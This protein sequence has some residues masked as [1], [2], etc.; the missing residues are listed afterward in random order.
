MTYREMPWRHAD[1]VVSIGATTVSLEIECERCP[2]SKWPGY[3]NIAPLTLNAARKRVHRH[4]AATGHI[5][6]VFQSV[7]R[8]YGPDPRD[9]PDPL[10]D[11]TDLGGDE[12]RP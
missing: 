1:G 10:D 7:N 12:D 5:V 11:A 4:I 2:Q 8:T 9:L 3:R 6:S